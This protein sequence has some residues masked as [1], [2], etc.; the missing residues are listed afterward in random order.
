MKKLREI[1]IGRL[2]RKLDR[3][4]AIRNKYKFTKYDTTTK[5][6]R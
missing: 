6:G 2:Q 3:E 1:K 4:I 5:L